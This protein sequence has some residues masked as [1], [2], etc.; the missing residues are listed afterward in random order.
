MQQAQGRAQKQYRV[1]N[2]HHTDAVKYSNNYSSAILENL[3]LIRKWVVVLAWDLGKTILSV[4]AV[5]MD[6][7]CET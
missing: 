6:A 3:L 5:S 4:L 1:M 2:L 7:N